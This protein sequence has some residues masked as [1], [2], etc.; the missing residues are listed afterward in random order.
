MEPAES[1]GPPSRRRHLLE[2]LIYGGVCGLLL[3]G[4]QAAEFRLLPPAGG[5]GA[6]A[7]LVAVLFAGLGLYFGATLRGEK[8]SAAP[9]PAS[10][11]P[12]A[13]AA[14]TAAAAAPGGREQLGITAREL[15]V[16]ALIAEGLSN[17][18]IAER[19][20]VSENTIKTHSSRLFE[21]LGARRRT[22]AVQLAKGLGLIA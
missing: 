15:E 11:P 2:I 17:R 8:A 7:A 6:Y 20:F 3:A 4:L 14:E 13:P 5:A 19:L 18:E 10:A 1:P 16:L 21:K 12:A 22:Q 9:P